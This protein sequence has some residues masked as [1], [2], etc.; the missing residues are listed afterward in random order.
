MYVMREYTLPSVRCS[1]LMFVLSATL[2]GC[3]GDE[4]E[5]PSGPHYTYVVSGGTLAA[6]TEQ[7]SEFAFDLDDNGTKDNALGRLLVTLG[8]QGFDPQKNLD[9]ALQSGQF[10]ML[11]DFQ[12]PSFTSAGGAGLTIKLGTD[13]MPAGC[14]N[15][16][17]PTTCGKH[18]DGNGSFAV[19]T[20]TSATGL[21]V[22]PVAGGTFDGGPGELAIGFII[23]GAAV[24]FQLIGARVEASGLSEAGITTALVGGAV[25]K[26]DVDAKLIPTI[27]TQLN[28]LI[29]RDCPGTTGPDC[30]CV[31]G[32][33]GKTLH[34][35]L[36]TDKNCEVTLDEVKSNE[37]LTLLLKPDVKIDGVDAISFGFKART[38]K[39]TVR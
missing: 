18:L 15:P 22:G 34:G 2:L 21:V 7:T 6:T 25:S 14:T 29:E 35:L 27:F 10:I 39:A 23:G 38:V 28:P 4:Q 30:A 13:P 16:S 36:D 17:D 3:G 11:V 9:T 24:D 31:N 19:K 8:S 37:L 20:G 1:S 12:T 33:T 5:P 26:S 32:S